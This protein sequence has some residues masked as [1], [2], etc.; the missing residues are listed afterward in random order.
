MN[1]FKIENT[2]LFASNIISDELVINSFPN[3]YKVSFNQFKNEFSENDVILI[4]SN[5]QRIYGIT[6]SKMIVVDALE[7]NKSIDTVLDI[8]QRLMDFDVDKGSTLTVIGGGIIQDLGA[9]AAKTYRRGI[10]WVFY[11]TTLLSQCDSC[12]GGKTALNF[13]KYKNQLALFS[14]PTEVIIDLNFLKTLSESDIISGY[15]EIVKLFL[16]GGEFYIDNYDSFTI[17]E[18]IFHALSIKKSIIE[19][20]EFEKNERRS[21]NYGHSFGH[22]IESLT[23]YKIPHGEAVMLGIEIINQLF[24]KSQKITNLINRYT[25]LKT[26][27]NIDVGLLIKG[28]KTDKKVEFGK[29]SFVVVNYPGQTVFLQH[30]IDEQLE[31]ITNEILA[32]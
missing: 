30:N 25:N 10:K 16:I 27:K 8:C 6:H 15:G 14:A 1:I 2:E 7:T 9:Y 22:V 20:D 28:L 3:T 18:K 11:P 12:I 4:D 13:R 29:I 21:L 26:I 23:E 31:K 5:V 19:H 32:D 17:K 24:T